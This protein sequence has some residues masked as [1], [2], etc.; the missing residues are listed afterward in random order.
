MF[1]RFPKTFASYPFGGKNNTQVFS[2]LV[3]EASTRFRSL[4]GL[5]HSSCGL[6][7]LLVWDAVFPTFSQ[8]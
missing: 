4:P 5:E 8:V 7:Y 6:G 1:I 3:L 2:L